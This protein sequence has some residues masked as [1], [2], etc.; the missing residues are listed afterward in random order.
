MDKILTELSE[1]K[2]LISDNFSEGLSTENPKILSTI[3]DDD[4]YEKYSVYLDKNSLVKLKDELRKADIDKVKK[5]SEETINDAKILKYLKKAIKL[6]KSND[7]DVF[8]NMRS[9]V[10]HFETRIITENMILFDEKIK[11]KLLG[12]NYDDSDNKMMN[13]FIIGISPKRNLIIRD[14]NDIEREIQVNTK[15]IIVNS[16]LSSVH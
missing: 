1:H 14:E 11:T 13:G 2:S 16:E 7:S 10:N 15:N 8:G 5:Y 6:F 12:S 9:V 4:S 3:S